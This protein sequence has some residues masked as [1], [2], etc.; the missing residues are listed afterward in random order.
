MIKHQT[1]K[2]HKHIWKVVDYVDYDPGV[3]FVECEIC[4]KDGKAVT[5]K[6][7]LKMYQNGCLNQQIPGLNTCPWQK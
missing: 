5:T 4:K 2:K 7:E 1:L 3:L 6:K